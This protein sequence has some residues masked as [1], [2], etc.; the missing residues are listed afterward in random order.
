M[1]EGNNKN[2]NYSFPSFLT[3]VHSVEH[4][5]SGWCFTDET[6]SNLEMDWLVCLKSTN[7]LHQ[8]KIKLPQNIH[9]TR[10]TVLKLI[11]STF[12]W[13]LKI[14]PWPKMSR[15]FIIKFSFRYWKPSPDHFLFLSHLIR[16][17]KRNHDR[18]KMLFN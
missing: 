15:N 4:L 1:E 13:Q 10:K 11:P 17:Y 18:C 14:N 2:L 3:L 16:I 6:V 5:P 8:A 7:C 9:G 12:N